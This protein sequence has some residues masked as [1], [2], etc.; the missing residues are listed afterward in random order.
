MVAG[1]LVVL[2]F[3]KTGKGNTFRFFQVLS[4][5]GVREVEEARRGRKKRAARD[6][7]I[8]RIYGC[9]NGISVVGPLTLRHFLSSSSHY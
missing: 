2:F 9:N 6:R 7:G 3:T 8:G 4:S 1:V 5:A